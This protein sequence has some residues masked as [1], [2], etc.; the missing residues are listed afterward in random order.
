MMM[1]S[2]FQ[3]EVAE[4]WLSVYMDDI[5]IHT[6]PHPEESKEQHQAQ[7]KSLVHCILDKLKE[8]NLYLKPKKCEFLKREINYLGV[9]VGNSQ[10]K[11]DLKKLQGVADWPPPKNPTN[12]RK[13][14]GFTGYY[15]YF[16]PNYSKIAWPL[17][18]LIKKAIPWHWEHNHFHTFEELKTQMCVAPVLIQPN[19]NN[20]SFLQVNASAYGLGIILSHK[21]SFTTPTLAKCSK[22][23]LHPIAYYSATFTPTEQNYDIY[24][25]ELLAMMKS[26]HH[27][28]PY[29]GWTKEPFTI[30]TDH[31]N[32]TYWKAPRN[33]NRRMARWHVNLQE[34]DFEIV[35]IPGKTNTTADALSRPSN[36]DQGENDNQNITLIPPT[37]C[38]TTLFIECSSN[39]LLHTI[40]ALTHDHPTAG[41]PGCN[42]NIR[43]TKQIHHWTNMN[44]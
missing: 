23:M 39:Q 25:Q 44:M 13:F 30:L 1:N 41:H 19:F 22:R 18:D 33:L 28:H 11:M 35:H 4:E 32:L 21:G 26:L 20:P 31:T 40:M 27:W 14:L 8:N 7:H 9:I 3:M 2:I 5:T 6:K 29:L 38:R 10:L 17:L 43:K 16:I 34:Y 36:T 24:K 42:E 37:H 15:R 12:I